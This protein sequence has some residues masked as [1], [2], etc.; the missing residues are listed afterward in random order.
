MSNILGYQDVQTGNTGPSKS[1]WHDCDILKMIRDPGY[2]YFY[3][4]DFMEGP[5]D[6]TTMNGWV[7]TEA[8]NGTIKTTDA[9]GGVI[10]LDSDT[11]TT[12]DHGIEIQLNQEAFKPAANKT[13][14]FEARVKP[15]LGSDNFFAGLC[16]TDTTIIASGAWDEANNS[17]IGWGRDVNDTAD[18]WSFVTDKASSIDVTNA[19]AATC[20]DATWYRVGFKVYTKNGALVVDPYLDGVK[21]TQ[22]TD[23]DDIP[24]VEMRISFATYVESGAVNYLDIDWV[25]CAQLR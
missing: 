10:E 11:S 12:D 19:L 2:G 20:T 21:Y 6:G 13:L 15:S 7:V 24:I 14:W 3:W 22:V 17:L 5:A 4:N 1:L 8:T 23:T 9:V 16:T 25:R 18:Y